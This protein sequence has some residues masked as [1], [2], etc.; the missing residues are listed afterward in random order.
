MEKKLK[1][2]IDTSVIGGC[3]DEEFAEWSNLLFE[4]FKEGKKIAVI[5][6][7]VL[8]ELIKAP[9]EIYN[10]INL[11]NPEFIQIIYRNNESEYLSSQYIIKNAISEKSRED[12]LHIAMATI[13]K[14]DIL[15]SWNFKHI[16]NYN[17]IL[18]F[19]S[20]NLE[21]G[22]KYLEIRSPKEVINYEE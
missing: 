17:R 14:V 22:Y 11:I 19:N 6:D 21:N 9:K 4:E 18:K 15:V 2:Y 1:I 12:A 5:S 10:K 7:V 20:I 16:V 13:A 8:E 3:F